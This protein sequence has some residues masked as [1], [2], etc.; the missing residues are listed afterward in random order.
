MPRITAEPRSARCP[1]TAALVAT[2]AQFG[3]HQLEELGDRGSITSASAWRELAR[4]AIADARDLDHLGG[5]ARVCIA[6]PWRILMSSASAV[7]AQRHRDVVGD[8]VAGRP[9][10]P[11]YGGSRR[12]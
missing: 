7:G 12:G 3:L 5:S 4:R 1:R 10:S 8:L 9:G 2:A 6:T 11:R